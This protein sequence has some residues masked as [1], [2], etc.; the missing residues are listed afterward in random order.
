VSILNGSQQ[1][2]NNALP[3]SHI[4]NNTA[5]PFWDDLYIYGNATP[6]QGIWYQFGNGGTNV[7]V[8]Y[9]LGRANA[10]SNGS[11]YH[12]TVGYSTSTPGT[13]IYTYYA[14]GGGNNGVN[15]A[16]GVQGGKSFLLIF[17]REKRMPYADQ[18]SQMQSVRPAQKPASPTP[19]S[20]RTSLRVWS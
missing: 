12:F 8:E 10:G 13:V 20:A 6:A 1:Y 15:A 11:V 3:S 19:S 4:P 17:R 18:S 5:A 14:T 9:Y 7:T 16:V 2:Q